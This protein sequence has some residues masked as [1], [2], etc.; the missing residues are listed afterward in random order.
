MQGDAETTECDTVTK[1]LITVFFQ[2]LIL[3]RSGHV[4]TQGSV[5]RL[6]FA[7]FQRLKVEMKLNETEAVK[8]LRSASLTFITPPLHCFHRT[9]ALLTWTATGSR[10]G[11]QN[12]SHA[13]VRQSPTPCNN[14][15]ISHESL[16]QELTKHDAV[17]F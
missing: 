10:A 8:T 7:A 15:Y 12:T 17:S 5:A 11:T 13:S 16:R 6:V 2:V 4:R 9:I 14:N 1:F 3:T